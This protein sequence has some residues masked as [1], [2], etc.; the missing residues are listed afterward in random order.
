MAGREIAL[1]LGWAGEGLCAGEGSGQWVLGAMGEHGSRVV[2]MLWRILGNEQ[3]VCD[4]YQETFLNLAHYEQGQAR[5]GRGGRRPENVKAY[6]FRTAGNIA[7]SMLRRRKIGQKVYNAIAERSVEGQSV[8]Y[9]QELDAAELQEALR[10]H[11]GRL[12]EHWREVVVLHDLAELPHGAGHIETSRS[13]LPDEDV[14]RNVKRH[15][16][17]LFKWP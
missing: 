13:R 12:P 10:H 3:D 8:D 17:S 6:L 9:G 16:R 1:S 2:T 15:S 7:V 4:A 14:N 11:L 5:E